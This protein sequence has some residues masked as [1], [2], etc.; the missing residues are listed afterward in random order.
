MVLG[1]PKIRNALEKIGA[2]PLGGAAVEF[3]NGIR[4]DVAHWAKIIMQ[5]EIKLP[6]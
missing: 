5:A 6:Q 2:E 1:E 3:G 4:A